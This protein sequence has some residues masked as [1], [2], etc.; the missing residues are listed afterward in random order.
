MLPE[1]LQQL[2]SIPS[3]LV[4]NYV[5]NNAYLISISSAA[6]SQLQSLATSNG[7]VQWIGAYQPSYKISAGLQQTNG[8]VKVRIAV[9]NDDSATATLQAVHRYVLGGGLEE[10]KT[11]VGQWLV[12]ILASASDLPSIAQLPGVLWISPWLPAQSRDEMQALVL[13]GFT[14]NPV[15]LTY[16]TAGDSYWNF[17]Y[18]TLGFSQNPADY[19]L[20][21]ICDTGVDTPSQYLNTPNE[22]LTFHPSFNYYL[23]VLPFVAG[24]VGDVASSLTPISC[25]ASITSVTARKLYDTLPSM[26]DTVGHG[27]RVASIAIG[28]DRLADEPSVNCIQQTFPSVT[29]S[30]TCIYCSDTLRSS[31][32]DPAGLGGCTIPAHPTVLTET[33]VGSC[34]SGADLTRVDWQNTVVTCVSESSHYERR[35]PVLLGTA[36]R[37]RFSTR[38]GCQSGR[39]LR[40]QQQ[41]LGSEHTGSRCGRR[42]FDVC[43]YQ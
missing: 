43:A 42:L 38:F 28:Y 41:C 24:S 31:G 10:H 20:L 1:W 29:S 39:V 22:F 32:I 7:P 8:L 3:V 14:N 19:P 12:T 15:N 40:S 34:P 6:E 18:T 13:A 27:T 36:R 35:S 17:L 16:P 21:D 25:P 37:V 33:K 5:P 30:G 2:R 9:L 23:D 11:A 4:I 26:T